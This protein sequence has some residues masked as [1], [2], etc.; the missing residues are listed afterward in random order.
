MRTEVESLDK[1]QVG[2]LMNEDNAKLLAKNVGIKILGSR[3]VVTQ[4]S[5]EIVW[6]RLV[7]KDFRTGGG[8]ALLEGIYSPTSSIEA[9]RF[10]LAYAAGVQG[11]L[12]TLDVSTAFMYAP[13][14]E[15]ERGRSLRRAQRRP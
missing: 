11:H 6:C 4:K 13:L 12:M 15:E 8:P 7:V 2:V 10:V 9:M 3:W 1:L 14:K 5:P